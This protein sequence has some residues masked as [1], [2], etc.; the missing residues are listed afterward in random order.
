[1]VIGG[2]PRHVAS[3]VDAELDVLV[4][5]LVDQRLDDAPRFRWPEQAERP[6][7]SHQPG[8][9][10]D[11]VQLADVVV[12]VVGDQHRIDLRKRHVERGELAHH[13]AAG[14][15]QDGVVAGLDQQRG[16]AACNIGTRASGAEQGDGR[17]HVL[18]FAGRVGGRPAGR[19]SVT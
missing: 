12:V 11:V 2:L 13:A 9:Q 1:M 6:G 15:D 17:R 18:M 5:D 10:N 16:G 14:V 3:L 4:V 7:A 8:R 19:G